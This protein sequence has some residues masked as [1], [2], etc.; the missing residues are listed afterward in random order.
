[1]HSFYSCL[2][3][4][5]FRFDVEFSLFFS[6]NFSNG[7]G[8][9][10]QL[11][12]N[13]T[14]LL[15]DNLE[16]S[17]TDALK[18]DFCQTEADCLNASILN[19]KLEIYLNQL[20][21]EIQNYTEINIP[22][23]R[24]ICNFF[25]DDCLLEN[26]KCVISLL[27]TK[28]CVC[29]NGFFDYQ[30]CTKNCQNNGIC[31]KKKA[32]VEDVAVNQDDHFEETQI[33]QVENSKDFDKDNFFE[34]LEKPTNWNGEFDAE[35]DKFTADDEVNWDIIFGKNKDL[36]SIENAQE[37]GAINPAFLTKSNLMIPRINL[38]GN[39]DLF[40]TDLSSTIKSQISLPGPINFEDFKGI[41][42]AWLAGP[43]NEDYESDHSEVY[44]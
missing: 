30:H 2:C 34:D 31:Y 3:D 18:E 16:H 9:P 13:Y 40:G 25:K 20:K 42:R 15:I 14:N 29:Q 35:W 33:H 32:K 6:N 10:N 11:T 12:K 23:N 17:L 22:E 36:D 43:N 26:R 5:F 28:K 7:N 8:D 24:E 4:C 41:P 37:T 27:K 1:M 19:E 44:F 39:K 21:N 38:N